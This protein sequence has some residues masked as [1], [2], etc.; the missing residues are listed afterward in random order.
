MFGVKEVVR[1][2][3]KALL[4][5]PLTCKKARVVKKNTRK[6]VRSST[7]HRVLRYLITTDKV[8]HGIKYEVNI[9]L[10]DRKDMQYEILIGRTF[11]ART[12]Y[13]VDVRYQPRK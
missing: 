10:S 9:G 2:G 8:I 7:G 4:F 13:L 3:K 1:D 5:K 12:R 11:S 6:Y